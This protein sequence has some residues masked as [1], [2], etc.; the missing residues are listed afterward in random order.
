MGGGSRNNLTAKAAKDARVKLQDNL[1]A[2]APRT[3]RFFTLS[4]STARLLYFLRAAGPLLARLR[5][6]DRK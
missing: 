3:Q 4:C 6:D 1:T 5:R 2:K